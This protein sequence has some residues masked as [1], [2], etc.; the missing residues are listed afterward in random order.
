M[1]SPQFDPPR[2]P[3]PP[4]TGRPDRRALLEAYQ[5]VVRT[6][7][8]RPS[9][10]RLIVPDRTPF[11]LGATAII[12]GLLALLVFQPAWLFNRPPAEPPQ[13]QEAS[14]RI[15]MFVEIDRVQ[16]FKEA[17]G[18]WPVS[19]VEAGGDSTGLT[20]EHFGEGFVLS[21]SNGLMTLRYQSGE[22]PE[23]FL[24]NSYQAVRERAQAKP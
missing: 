1:T 9:P 13:L 22:S 19:I 12:L 24:G 17:H 23:A 10:R 16:R 4:P 7:R 11:W 21:G 2:E 8:A 5:E 14:L 3:L 18:R 20:F 6:T 15:R